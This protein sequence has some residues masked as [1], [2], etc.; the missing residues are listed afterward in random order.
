MG[1]EKPS[2]NFLTLLAYKRFSKKTYAVWMRAGP[3]PE[4]PSRNFLTLLAYKRFSKK[5]Y[6]VWMRAG[7][8]P[9]HHRG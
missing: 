8:R 9:F 5:T 4:K 7:P 2:R 1:C 3:R 6:A